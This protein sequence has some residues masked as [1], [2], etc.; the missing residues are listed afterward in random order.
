MFVRNSHLFD[1]M[2]H[3]SRRSRVSSGRDHGGS[4]RDSPC[5]LV[6]GLGSHFPSIF[7]LFRSRGRESRDSVQSSTSARLIVS[8]LQTPRSRPWQRTDSIPTPSLSP[9][10]LGLLGDLAQFF[11]FGKV[12]RGI[13]V[14]V[15]G[16]FQSCLGKDQLVANQIGQEQAS[17]LDDFLCNGFKVLDAAE[18]EWI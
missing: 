18:H 2:L 7:L 12:V 10:F 6:K 11:G 14:P 3:Q 9:R 8:S 5:A 13:L 4:T 16:F 17:H 1:G 15:V